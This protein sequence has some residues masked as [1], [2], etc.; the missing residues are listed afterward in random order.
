MPWA[1]IPAILLSDERDRHDLK[2]VSMYHY[3]DFEAWQGHRDELLREAGERRLARQLR[4]ARSGQNAP[5]IRHA[6]LRL[7]A[8]LIEGKKKPKEQTGESKFLAT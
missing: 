1:D 6:M 3:N 7:V 2:E 4:A 8:S 5:Q